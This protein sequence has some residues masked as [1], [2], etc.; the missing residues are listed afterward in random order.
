MKTKKIGTIIVCLFLMAQMSTSNNFITFKER[1]DSWL[2]S[3]STENGNGYDG[4][5]GDGTTGSGGLTGGNGS[6]SNNDPRIGAPIRDTLPL[7][8][9]LSGIYCVACR[10]RIKTINSNYKTV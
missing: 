10:K 9:V 3:S 5:P 8:L 2:K 7:I 6:G 4:G 1:T